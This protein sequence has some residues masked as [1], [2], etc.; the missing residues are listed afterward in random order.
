MKR[1]SLIPIAKIKYPFFLKW[2][3]TFCVRYISF[4]RKSTM[5]LVSLLLLNCPTENSPQLLGALNLPSSSNYISIV[6]SSSTTNATE[7]IG[8][9]TYTIVLLTAPTSDV[10]ISI[11]FDTAQLKINSST[12]SPVQLTFTSANWSTAQTVTVEALY[13]NVTEGSHTQ[14]ITHTSSSSDSNYSGTIASNVVVNI[15]DT[16]SATVKGSFQSGNHTL[17]TASDTITLTT[18][19]DSTKAFVTCNAKLT[20]SNT[21]CAATCQLNTAGTQVQIQSGGGICS[22]VDW[23]VMEYATAATVQRGST[24]LSAG[25]SISNVT[26]SSISTSKTFVIAYTRSSVG[27]NNADGN[28]T[29]MAR[30]TSSTNLELTRNQTTAAATVEWQVIQFDGSNVRSGTVTLANGITNTTAAIGSSV[31]LGSSFLIFNYK[32][33]TA[34]AGVERDYY[35]RGSYSNN[36]TLSFTRRNGNQDVDISWFAV[37]MTDGTTAQSGSTTINGGGGTS[38]TATL[39]PAVTTTKSM[40]VFS[41]DT[42]T[43]DSGVATQDSGTYTSTFNS[44]TQIQFTRNNDEN[45]AATLD[46]FVI[47]FQ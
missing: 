43:G 26:I 29:T 47:S 19:V 20:S 1:I 38:V 8:S 12:T 37:E 45:N 24:S 39:S 14:T 22:E 18:T 35:V 41:N 28:R 3:I 34:I 27:G 21:N 46:W 36:S 40:I 10:T 15:T 13:D 31:N 7:G 42:A 44:S 11:A 16:T 6:E 5:I 33:A 23:Y 2:E 25:T 9:D 17:A 4:V 30:L 32:A